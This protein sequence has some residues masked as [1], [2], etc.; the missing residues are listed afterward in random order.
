MFARLCLNIRKAKPD[1][2]A[3]C[4]SFPQF[5]CIQKDDIHDQVGIMRCKISQEYEK[6]GSTKVVHIT[7]INNMTSNT[8]QSA[9][10]KVSLHRTVDAV[11]LFVCSTSLYYVKKVTPKKIWGN[12]TNI[13]WL[14]LN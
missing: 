12:L 4:S 14:Q 1:R 8:S 3:S 7:K 5:Y 10:I 2:L 13:P 6:L 9:Y 11:P